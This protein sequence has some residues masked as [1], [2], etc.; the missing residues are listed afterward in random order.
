MVTLRQQCVVAGVRAQIY[1]RQ[2]RKI[3]RRT[4]MVTDINMLVSRGLLKDGILSDLKG[5]K[6]YKNIGFDLFALSDIYRKNW[7]N[8]ATRTS[9]KEEELNQVEDLADKLMTAVGEREARPR[10]R[11]NPSAIARPHSQSSSTRTMRCAPSSDSFAA[12]KATWTRL[13]RRSS[14]V[15]PLPRRSPTTRQRPFPCRP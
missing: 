4:V 6:G 2:E 10:S 12:S 9:M 11:P 1:Q 5:V 8:I 15:A 7:T 14:S 13:R 3:E